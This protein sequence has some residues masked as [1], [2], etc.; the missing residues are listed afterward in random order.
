MWGSLDGVQDY[1]L[2]GLDLSKR[3]AP[4]GA[5]MCGGRSHRRQGAGTSSPSLGKH[6]EQDR[7]QASSGVHP[8]PKSQ[9]ARSSL[10]AE[11]GVA[12][13]P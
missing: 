5:A 4:T 6:K 13:A 1:H 8:L 12:T 10:T 9:A 2:L 3:V 7:Q 11:D